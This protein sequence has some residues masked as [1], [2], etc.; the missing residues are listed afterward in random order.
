MILLML[1]FAVGTAVA[2][3]WYV[4]RELAK[5]AVRVGEYR[6]KL[7]QQRTMGNNMRTQLVTV[8]QQLT[9]A[10]DELLRLQKR[11]LAEKILSIGDHRYEPSN[12]VLTSSGFAD[13]LPVAG[14]RETLPYHDVFSQTRQLPVEGIIDASR[15]KR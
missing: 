12:Q 15:L 2:A 8:N 13:T 6:A 3:K 5:S 9:A 14:F 10:R 4:K 7:E 1:T 11:D